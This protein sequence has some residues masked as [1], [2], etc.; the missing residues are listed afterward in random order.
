MTNV[1]KSPEA[2]LTLE[3][4]ESNQVFKSPAWPIGGWLILIALSVLISPVRLSYGIYSLYFPLFTDGTMTLLMDATSEYYDF[5]LA[6]LIIVET[7]LNLVMLFAS[8]YMAYLFFKRRSLLPKFYIVFVV[9]SLVFITVDA[10]VAGLILGDVATADRE[11]TTEIIRSTISVII[12]VPYFLMSVRVK[13][14][15]VFDRDGHRK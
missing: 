6:M 3:N 13:N 12:W 2:D 11:T 8:L 10:F 4:T 1:Y 7:I 15:F 5:H 9:S 14:T